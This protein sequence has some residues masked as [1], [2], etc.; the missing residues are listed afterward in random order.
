M[1]NFTNLITFIEERFYSGQPVLTGTARQAY[2][3]LVAWAGQSKGALFISHKGVKMLYQVSGLGKIFKLDD[4]QIGY[5]PPRDGLT[6]IAVKVQAAS[7]EDA[8]H[9]AYKNFGD[10]HWLDSELYCYFAA[11]PTITETPPDQALAAAGAEPLP[12][13]APFFQT[14]PPPVESRGQANAG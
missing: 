1:N 3:V 6:Q 5:I 13:F 11:P 14:T 4:D 12:G 8:L 9:V 2:R 10:G 7:L